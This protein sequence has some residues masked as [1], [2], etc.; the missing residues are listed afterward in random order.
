MPDRRRETDVQLSFHCHDLEGG[1]R[2]LPPSYAQVS[3]SVFE[4]LWYTERQC[5]PSMVQQED[6]F[7][8]PNISDCILSCV[9]LHL[10]FY[11]M[12]LL[13]IGCKA[14]LW[15][16]KKMRARQFGTRNLWCPSIRTTFDKDNPVKVFT[17]K[18]PNLKVL[19]ALNLLTLMLHEHTFNLV[20]D[21]SLYRKIQ[22]YRGNLGMLDTSKVPM[23]KLMALHQVIKASHEENNELLQDAPNSFMAIADTGCSF[24]C[25]NDKRDFCPGTITELSKP[26]TL[27][28][29]AGGLE[30]RY[31]GDVCWETIDDYVAM[32]CP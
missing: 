17:S 28:G 30:V 8:F 27:G 5:K 1:I 4:L 11:N 6:H 19:T 9:K 14:V 13:L 25:T 20:S 26:L 10:Y 22:T 12:W 7:V 31:Q 2:P 16:L 23:D 18:N 21:T 3:A 32:F 15:A 29:I 24:T